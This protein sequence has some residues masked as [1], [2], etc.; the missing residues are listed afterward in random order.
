M[1]YSPVNLPY[2]NLIIR[3]ANEPRREEEKILL[4]HFHMAV[5]RPGTDRL[6]ALTDI[7]IHIPP[8]NQQTNNYPEKDLGRCIVK[9]TKL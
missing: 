4:L 8:N 3:P 2:V 5:T 9:S 6:L 1:Y 7:H